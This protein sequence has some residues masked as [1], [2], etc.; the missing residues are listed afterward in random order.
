MGKGKRSKK[1]KETTWNMTI[2]EFIDS[3][4]PAMREY[5][6][7][8][9]GTGAD[10]KNFHPEDLASNALCFMESVYMVVQ[11]FEVSPKQDKNLWT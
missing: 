5:L 6:K 4:T 11:C 7:S 2:D 3:I 1:E 9:R 10:E 8:N